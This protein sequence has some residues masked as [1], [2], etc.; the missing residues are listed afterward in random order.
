MTPAQDAPAKVAELLARGEPV[1]DAAFDELYPTAVRQASS[2]CWTPVEVVR[3]TLRLLRPTASTRLLDIGSG[4]GK[5]CAIAALI[6]PGQYLGIERSP[7][8]HE[9]A[10]ETRRKLGAER[11]AFL[12]GDALDLDWSHYDVLYFYNPFQEFL[13]RS[14]VAAM[15]L[16][17]APVDDW[18][19]C[20]RA[21]HMR[22][23]Q[24]APGT[25]V[26]L[27]NGYGMDLPVGYEQLAGGRGGALTLWQKAPG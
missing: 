1:P 2:V 13:A 6:A 16:S 7:E 22:L 21:A 27:F 24:L 20:A 15:G 19:R 9:V 11:A 18:A 10:V 23:H 17:V 3:E 26:V 12:L 14:L 8:L 4:P 25:R 5:F